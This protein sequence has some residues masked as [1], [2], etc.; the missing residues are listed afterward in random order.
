MKMHH[1]FA[2]SMLLF[3]GLLGHAQTDSAKTVLSSDPA[4]ASILESLSHPTTAHVEANDIQVPVGEYTH[5]ETHGSSTDCAP[6]TN[7]E[8]EY[9]L[10]LVFNLN[11]KSVKV[12]GGCASYESP[13]CRGFSWLG[14][15][16]PNCR[17]TSK[18]VYVCTTEG[19]NVFLIEKKKWETIHRYFIYPVERSKPNHRYYIPLATINGVA[20]SPD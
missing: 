1:Q 15:A 17:Y 18:N 19:S 3:A 12:V 9:Q 11:G 13:H 20:V 4:I 2:L 6:R 7:F 8:R 16:S 5:C 10:V 14:G